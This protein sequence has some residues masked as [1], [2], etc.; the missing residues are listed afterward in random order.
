MSEPE[1]TQDDKTRP[2][3]GPTQH[4]P[5]AEAPPSDDQRPKAGP[6]LDL[7]LSSPD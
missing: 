1:N 4:A 7:P 3:S 5:A 6:S 2:E